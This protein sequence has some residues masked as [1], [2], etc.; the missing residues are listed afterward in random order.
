MKAVKNCL[1]HFQLHIQNQNVLIRSDNTTVCQYINRQGGAKLTQL[2]NLTMRLWEYT[3]AHKVTLKAV[4]I[5]GN[6]NILADILS[7]QRVLVTEWSLS[8]SVVEKLFQIWGKPMIDLFATIENKKA[9]LFCS[10][11][12]HPEAYAMDAP[13]N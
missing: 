10:W 12:H 3:I 1:Q 2:C 11:I 13:V 8:I 7:R 4:H 9:P 5:M 6:K